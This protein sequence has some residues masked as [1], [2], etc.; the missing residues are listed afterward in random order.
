MHKAALLQHYMLPALDA[1]A[2]DEVQTSPRWQR[3][4]KLM[5]LLKN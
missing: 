5:K 1:G 3:I 2:F 4:Q